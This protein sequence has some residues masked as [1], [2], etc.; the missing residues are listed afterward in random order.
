MKTNA[1]I[2]IC[3]NAPTSIFSIYNGKP[4]AGGVTSSDLSETGFIK[5]IDLI[6][7]NLLQ[8]YSEVEILSVDKQI[9]KFMKAV[10]SYSPDAI[11]NFVESVEGIASYEYCVAGLYQILGFNYTGNIPSCLGNCLNKVRT[12]NILRSYGINTPDSQT[13]K[14]NDRFYEKRFRLIFPVIL[15]PANEDASIGVSELSVAY[16]F[17]GLRKQLMFLKENYMQDVLIEEFIDGRELNVAVLGNSVLPISE[18]KFDGLPEGLPKIVTY[19]G[20]WIAETV[21]YNNTKPVCP[22]KLNKK[23]KSK[24]EETALL[25]FKAMNCRDY[26]R[27]DIRLNKIGKP[28]VIEVNPNPDISIDSGFAR[29]AAAAGMSHT[30]LLCKLADFALT[31]KFNDTQIKAS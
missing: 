27:V 2:L 14:L 20:K 18:I 30:D 10:S 19:E 22:A 31:R 3:Y 25:A 5:E 13:V 24:V 4:A 17:K 12:K 15:K 16:D 21:Y 8:R 7:R 6:K 28:Y 23:I 9:E 26:A 1:K 29:A 11:I